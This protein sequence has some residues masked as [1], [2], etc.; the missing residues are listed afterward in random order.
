VPL[1]TSTLEKHF[2]SCLADDLE[3][4]ILTLEEIRKQ[5]PSLNFI[6]SSAVLAAYEQQPRIFKYCLDH[7]AS[8]DHNLN[9]AIETPIASSSV[10]F[11][12]DQSREWSIPFLEA[13]YEVDWQRIQSSRKALSECL[14][15]SDRFS[16]EIV[17]WFFDHGAEIAPDFF[18]NMPCVVVSAAVVQN[19]LGKHSIDHFKHS[20]FLQH[21]A[22]VGATDVVKL[23]LDAGADINEG[24]VGRDEREPGPGPALED[25]V[26]GKHVETA[27]L[28]LERGADTR[29]LYCPTYSDEP[30]TIAGRQDGEMAALL[31]MYEPRL[32][33]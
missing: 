19:F 27:K 4:F 25:A 21:A 3:T 17:A 18:K 26:K 31:R 9:K 32:P 29:G 16:P 28:L 30:R 23:L 33:I 24:P 10:P 22:G 8:L 7:G 6:Q 15:S 5:Y 14:V 11:R 12:F 20:G 1:D 13:L 2:C